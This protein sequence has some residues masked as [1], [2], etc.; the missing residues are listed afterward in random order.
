MVCNQIALGVF[1]N[2]EL[3]PVLP[4]VNSINDILRLRKDRRISDFRAKIQ[5]WSLALKEDDINLDKMKKEMIEANKKIKTLGKCERVST[6]ITYL[7]L[8]IDI[9]LTLSGVSMGLVTSLPSFGIACYS[10]IL[11]KDY[12]WYLFGIQ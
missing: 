4:V 6:W 10:K 9:A 8:P 11:Q 3:R 1:F 12:N 5:E 7:S 2:E